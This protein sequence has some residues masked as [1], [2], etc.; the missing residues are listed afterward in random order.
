VLT[1]GGGQLPVLETHLRD[2]LRLPVSRATLP[3]VFGSVKR[4]HDA[5]LTPAL[6]ASVYGALAEKEQL[7]NA[8]ALSLFFKTF[9]KRFVRFLK[10]LLP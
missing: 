9:W 7:Q 5:S 10:S 8:S 4:H 1:G 3:K 2:A 6:G